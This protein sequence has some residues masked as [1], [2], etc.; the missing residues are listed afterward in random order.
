MPL[1]GVVSHS[2]APRR[3]GRGV[4]LSVERYGLRH[5]EDE[6]HHAG[7]RRAYAWFELR[8]DSQSHRHSVAG[9]LSALSTLPNGELIQRPHT[10]D[11]PERRPVHSPPLDDSN[12]RWSTAAL[13]SA[14]NRV[15]RFATPSEDDRDNPWPH[16]LPSLA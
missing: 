10:E 2:S 15:K 8:C 5:V 12:S 11:T 9:R 3:P 4:I 13:V 1:W 16:V 14:A 7:L 6:S